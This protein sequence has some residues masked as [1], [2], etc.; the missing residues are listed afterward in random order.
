MPITAA[1]QWPP[2]NHF[3]N[4]LVNSNISANSHTP[5]VF[6]PKVPVFTYNVPISGYSGCSRTAALPAAKLP[7]VNYGVPARAAEVPLV[8]YNVPGASGTRVQVTL[9]LRGKIDPIE[10]RRLI[11]EMESKVAKLVAHHNAHFA[12]PI[13][14][15]AMHN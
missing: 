9:D 15:V 7:I 8:D 6:I 4:T 2:A 14:A 1:P 10:Y 11:L 12:P 3:A 13:P 5:I